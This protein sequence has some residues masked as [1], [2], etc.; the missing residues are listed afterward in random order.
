MAM[1]E[2]PEGAEAQANNLK[3]LRNILSP[4]Q[5]RRAQRKFSQRCYETAQKHLQEKYPGLAPSGETT[6]ADT[7]QFTPTDLGGTGHPHSTLCGNGLWRD[8]PPQAVHLSL[9]R[10]QSNPAAS[11]GPAEHP[12][13]ANQPLLLQ[14][15]RN[16]VALHQQEAT[17]ATSPLCSGHSL[18]WSSQEESAASEASYSSD[19]SLAWSE[20]ATQNEA[21]QWT[22]S[23][24]VLEAIQ[25]EATQWTSQ[26]Q[27]S[28]D[29]MV[30]AIQNEATQW[31]SQ[32]QNIP[33]A[34]RQSS[35]VEGTFFLFADL[36]ATV[37][38]SW[39]TCQATQP[40]LARTVVANGGQMVPI[41]AN[42]LPARSTS[43]SCQEHSAPHVKSGICLGPSP[44]QQSPSTTSSPTVNQKIPKKLLIPNIK[45]KPIL[46][47]QF[48][49]M[50]AS[51]RQQAVEFGSLFEEAKPTQECK[52][53]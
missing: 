43:P 4:A 48:D 38:A 1:A 46:H 6:Q 45:A 22:Q 31:T 5:L 18:S 25:N 12:D 19:H 52:Q 20:E 35:T 8:S 11:Q 32:S 29:E 50:F 40:I 21:T 3:R 47:D 13:D 39:N 23:E 7:M 16:L 28:I 9:E 14:W 37:A 44:C 17:S 53:Q 42:Q 30:E 33:S 27:Q 36:Q 15:M 24:A 51:K 34:T 10:S 2:P 49:Q 41:F 26:P